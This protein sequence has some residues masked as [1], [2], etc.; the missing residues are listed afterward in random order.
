MNSI[1]LKA[2][3]GIAACAVAASASLLPIATAEAAPVQAPATPALI[4]HADVPLGGWW[5][6][7]RAYGPV[8][9][10]ASS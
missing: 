10:D 2:K 8:E 1:A 7:E 5:H 4:G 3:V 6:Q 9:A